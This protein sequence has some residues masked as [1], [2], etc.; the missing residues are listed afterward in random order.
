MPS[1]K[2]GAKG[3]GVVSALLDVALDRRRRDRELEDD[4]RKFSQR[5]M[6]AGI[7]A[8]VKGGF[9]EP[10]F[11]SLPTGQ[12][13]FRGFRQADPFARH[14]LM[15][16]LAGR[17]EGS[18]PGVDERA[19]PSVDASSALIG[20][21]TKRS[22]LGSSQFPMAGMGLPPGVTF[23]EGGLTMPL[24]EPVSRVPSPAELRRFGFDLRQQFLKETKDFPEVRRAA[25]KMN[26][27]LAETLSRPTGNRAAVDQAIIVTFNKILDPGSVVRESEY[28]RTP[29]TISALNRAKG[30]IGKLT[31]GGSGVTDEDRQDIVQLANRLLDAAGQEY[32]L[33]YRQTRDYA[34]ALDIEPAFVLGGLQPYQADRMASDPVIAALESQGFRVIEELR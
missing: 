5:L 27:A 13:A 16:L 23:S 15:R 7:E 21:S 2:V 22:R 18:L 12:S 9:I 6:E 31:R 10:V 19:Q 4:R 32:D 24:T 25:G 17:P 8:G 3:E 29:E 26:T 14:P 30:F 11:D 33:Q 1:Y 28:A 20:D 34:M